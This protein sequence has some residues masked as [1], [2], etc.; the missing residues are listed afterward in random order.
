MPLRDS[1]YGSLTDSTRGAAGEVLSLLW[2]NNHGVAYGDGKVFV[3]RFDDSVVAL[4]QKQAK[5]HGRAPVADFMTGSLST[6]PLNSWK[7]VART[8]RH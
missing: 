2:P 8:G 6:P 1:S 5:S 7:P 4:T 3:G